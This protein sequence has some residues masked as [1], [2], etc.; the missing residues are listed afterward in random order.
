MKS[1][2][3]DILPSKNLQCKPCDRNI[4]VAYFTKM[5]KSQICKMKVAKLFVLVYIV[6]VLGSE[7]S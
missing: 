4:E 1:V 6:N 2:A 7:S 5:Q 3:D